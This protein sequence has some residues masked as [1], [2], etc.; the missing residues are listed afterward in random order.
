M[1]KNRFHPFD[2]EQVELTGPA[3]DK[4]DELIKKLHAVLHAVSE[5]NRDNREMSDAAWQQS[6][7]DAVEEFNAQNGTFFDE[8]E[9]VTAWL[10][11]R[12]KEWAEY[13][14]TQ[15]TERGVAMSERWL[16]PK[17]GLRLP[18]PHESTFAVC[19]CGTKMIEETGD[20][21]GRH[22]GEWNAL[23]E[24]NERLEFEMAELRARLG[25][26]R[27]CA[28]LEE[29]EQR[30][31]HILKDALQKSC[32]CAQVDDKEAVECTE[33]AAM[34][35]ENERLKKQVREMGGE[36][37]NS[38]QGDAFVRKLILQ[39]HELL[40]ENER[41]KKELHR[42]QELFAHKNEADDGTALLIHSLREQI[43]DLEAKLG[44]PPV[45]AHW[46]REPPTKPGWYHVVRS[47]GGFGIV[48]VTQALET[49]VT[50]TTTVIQRAGAGDIAWF[51]S[52]TVRLPAPPKDG[53]DD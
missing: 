38:E 52:E 34:G 28:T 13:I 5:L 2:P 53:D 9:A 1:T 35:E 47:A 46:T 17:C 45:T 49:K 37:D 11:G 31:V 26:I 21:Q 25:T 41:L 22:I 24:E 15:S 50:I 29:S 51:W 39:S 10:R 4:L 16:C 18:K 48:H 3:V 6:L 12:L 20:L 23:A 32:G 42:H 36:P 14:K 8:N 19:D 43:N 7:V 30:E 40:E 27:A 33:H 44:Y